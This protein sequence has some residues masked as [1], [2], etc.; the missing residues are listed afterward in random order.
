MCFLLKST[1]YQQ[2]SCHCRLLLGPPGPSL[3]H[4]PLGLRLG[5]GRGRHQ[6]LAVPGPGLSAA[7]VPLDEGRRLPLR[8]LQPR[9]LPP[10]P[11][12]KEGGRGTVPVLRQELGRHHRVG[13]DPGQG[14]M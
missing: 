11:V 10:D 7:R 6:D 1:L 14:R 12:R 4:A 5:G 2:L 8:R 3:H 13:E 9:A